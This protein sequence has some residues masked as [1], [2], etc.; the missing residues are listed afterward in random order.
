[1][2]TCAQLIASVA[3]TMARWDS[4]VRH[5]AKNHQ[6]CVAAFNAG[7]VKALRAGLSSDV[8]EAN[9]QRVGCLFVDAFE[10]F[11]ALVVHQI[12]PHRRVNGVDLQ[13]EGLF[14]KRD[15]QN[16]RVF[17][18]SHVNVTSRLGVAVDGN[19]FPGSGNVGTV[20]ELVTNP[21]KPDSGT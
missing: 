6:G 21:S 14:L 10:D 3:G 19:Q 18:Y 17:D 15:R 12:D 2:N 16:E 1:M 11:T 7:I 9:L 8:G 4:S 13:P 20:A 5:P